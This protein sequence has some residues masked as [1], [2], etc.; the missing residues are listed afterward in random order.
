M[1]VVETTWL[2]HQ[3]HHKQDDDDDQEA[4]E[5]EQEEDKTFVFHLFDKDEADA[6]RYELV[7]FHSL[8]PNVPA[9]TLRGM[10]DY[11]TST[12]LGLWKAAY[13]MSD[14][15]VQH[16]H[17]IVNQR[18]LELGAGMGYCGIV[19]YHLGAA[20]VLL[21]DGDSSVLENLRYNVALNISKHNHHHNGGERPE[22]G[23][24]DDD[25]DEA[26]HDDEDEASDSKNDQENRYDN[27]NY[28]RADRTDE[29]GMPP[30]PK[31]SS[32]RCDSNTTN[33][34]RYV[35]CPQL[36]WGQNL[37]EFVKEYGRQSVL[38]ASDCVY[39]TTSLKPL[40][41]TMQYL[42]EPNHGLVI[43]LNQSASQASIELVLKVASDHGF[44]WTKESP[45]HDGVYLFR[46]NGGS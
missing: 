22:G 31:S 4:D 28:I 16:S 17:Y 1:V 44:T 38:I 45:P 19:A 42:L 13:A 40:W 34:G 10:I 35:A 14:Y 46:P 12:G 25:E 21:T 43:F 7:E 2:E 5:E 6:A 8:A 33:G 41:A 18:V 11:P 3:V 27:N 15:L 23:D 32:I 39:M 36:I 29:I 26:S 20:Q 37:P 24:Q 9:I 30:A